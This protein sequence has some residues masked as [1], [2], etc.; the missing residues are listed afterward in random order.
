MTRALAPE[1]VLEA[2]RYSDWQR[3]TFAFEGKGAAG[4]YTATH[5]AF[6]AFARLQPV[7]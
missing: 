4:G 3:P 7:E 6:A 5:Y 2:P 1:Y